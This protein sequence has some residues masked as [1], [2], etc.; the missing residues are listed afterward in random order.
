VISRY[1]EQL[2]NQQRVLDSL[3]FLSPAILMQ[4]ALNDIA[5]TGGARHADFLTQVDAYHRQWREY[6]VPKIFAKAQIA[7][8]DAIPRFGYREES[9]DVVAS[10]VAAA[11]MGLAVPAVVIAAIGLRRLSRFA[12]A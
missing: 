8:V 3:R 1:E 11:S 4:G 10:R 12:V 7:D 2:A 6:F 9:T 5:G